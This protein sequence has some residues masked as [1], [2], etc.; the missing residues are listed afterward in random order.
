MIPFHHFRIVPA[1][2]DICIAL[3]SAAPFFRGRAS[4]DDAC[5]VLVG[6][7]DIAV[8]TRI[9]GDVPASVIAK[10]AYVLTIVS[11]AKPTVR[12]LERIARFAHRLVIADSRFSVNMSEM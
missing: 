10:L 12:K 5:W 9:V 2:L 6:E 1:R 4:S 7:A 11:F 3:H 8:W